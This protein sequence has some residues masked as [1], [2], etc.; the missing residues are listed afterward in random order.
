M[1]KIFLNILVGTTILSAISATSLSIVSCGSTADNT[2]KYMAVLQRALTQVITAKRQ[3]SAKVTTKKI[4]FT[5][6]ID[7]ISK[8][9]AKIIAKQKLSIATSYFKHLYLFGKFTP[10]IG[11][12]YKGVVKVTQNKDSRPTKVTIIYDNSAFNKKISTTAEP[13]STVLGEISINVKER[14]LLVMKKLL[15]SIDYKLSNTAYFNTTKSTW[16][17]PNTPVKTSFIDG[18]TGA[19][20]TGANIPKKWLAISQDPKNFAKI[21][22]VSAHGVW[23]SQNAG[24]TFTS[25]FFTSLT[26]PM[27]F[28]S[29]GTATNGALLADSAKIGWGKNETAVIA[30]N[31]IPNS[32]GH[33]PKVAKGWST[34]N[35]VAVGEL[36]VVRL[37]GVKNDIHKTD[38]VDT[39]AP[40]FYTGKFGNYTTLANGFRL[41]KDGN[42]FWATTANI[43]EDLNY[44]GTYEMLAT[45]IANVASGS[46]HRPIATITAAGEP[47][48]GPQAEMIGM[49]ISPDEKNLWTYWTSGYAMHNVIVNGKIDPKET[50]YVETG[51]HQ[52][53][54]Q[55][56]AAIASN[57]GLYYVSGGHNKR[58][59]STKG[60]MSYAGFVSNDSKIKQQFHA[61]AKDSTNGFWSYSYSG[62]ITGKN[63][64]EILSTGN[65]NQ[66]YIIDP[67][68]RSGISTLSTTGNFAGYAP[69]GTI[70]NPDSPSG[71]G[72]GIVIN[73]RNTTSPII[74]GS[75]YWFPSNHSTAFNLNNSKYFSQTALSASFGKF[76]TLAIGNQVYDVNDINHPPH[77]ITTTTTTS[78]AS[79]NSE[80][81]NTEYFKSLSENGIS[82]INLTGVSIE[83]KGSALTWS[84]ATKAI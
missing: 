3:E 72:M 10:E 32:A 5:M 64:Y 77:K 75:T 41:D 8:A 15:A 65:V 27:E 49:T 81:G 61:F 16:S 74:L 47:D 28:N 69:Y 2:D 36:M 40:V 29:H 11:S 37:A 58:W 50:G 80:I 4:S 53:E 52:L 19:V 39:I 56:T 7:D 1:K 48:L 45:D 59:A 33:G 68:N 35:V 38:K 6:S 62:D 71:S 57:T 25:A 51:N 55:A 70:A 73:I 13:E 26:T 12:S 54:Y 42:L 31:R 22:A 84:A 20:I 43:N 78:G 76:A 66:T 23:Y 46:N 63:N 24:K 30:I 18:E 60:T 34:W 14:H 82:S 17:T 79:F 67:N 9:A 83:Y 21:I 44:Q